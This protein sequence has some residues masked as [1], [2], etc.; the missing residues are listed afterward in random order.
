MQS[1]HELL[2]LLRPRSSAMQR[3][4]CGL[5]CVK[6]SIH[7]NNQE[8]TCRVL[9]VGKKFLTQIDSYWQRRVCVRARVNRI[10]GFPRA[11]TERKR[12]PLPSVAVSA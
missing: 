3:P 9:S 10:I 8:S 4:L 5:Q 6:K 11:D 2:L 1:H 12:P 7:N